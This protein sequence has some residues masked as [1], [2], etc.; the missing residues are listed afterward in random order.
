MKR[1]YLLLPILIF[2]VAV[3]TGCGEELDT[4]PADEFAAQDD[5]PASPT[6]DS[7]GESP[8]FVPGRIIVKF[9][10]V[11][12]QRQRA[13]EILAGNHVA[14]VV[15]DLADD[16]LL[17]ELDAEPTDQR[18]ILTLE[19]RTLEAI[20]TL[21]G[22]DDVEYVHEDT[23]MQFV[24]TPTDP[25]YPQQWSY[26][27]IG[28]PQAWNVVTGNKVIAVL[29]TGKLPHP[30]FTSRWLTGYDFYE[31][32]ADATDTGT[33]H[34]GLHVAGILAARTNN[35]I[36]GAGVCWGC[37][38]LP[39]RVGGSQGVSISS[40]INAIPW[41]VQQGAK[42]INMSFAGG[43]ACAQYP[44]LQNVINQATQSGAVLVAAA[45]NTAS[46]V[47]SVIPASCTNVIAV[48]ASDQGG[49]LASYSNRGSRI[50]I[51]APG[52]GEPMYGQ[53]I[54]CPADPLYQGSYT[55][56][57]GVVASWAISKP[58]SQLLSSD[59]CHRYLSGTSMAAPHVA[60]VAALMLT[61]NPQLTPAQVKDIIKKA[62]PTPISCNNQCGAGRINAYAAVQAA[63][64]NLDVF[65]ESGG[66]NFICDATQV[67]G[68]S[69]YTGQWQGVTNAAVTSSLGT[70]AS[71]VCNVNQT[72]T[73]NVTITDGAGRAVT[74]QKSFMCQQIWQ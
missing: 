18:S 65:C 68:V 72:A 32:D 12:S 22:R 3:Y 47:A 16:A 7:A 6:A 73:V 41:A 50:D 61:R 26:P 71:G 57:A 13:S 35:G 46:D 64:F 4:A 66:G 11:G 31:N 37:P 74:K 43:A 69:P 63:T 45:G 51:T 2:A 23:L 60:G 29:D 5:T 25:L 55:G 28:L 49:N 33:W 44:S 70:H 52:G 39:V 9:R 42:V 14:H 67:G 59:Y 58:G 20:D 19:E 34:H 40:V 15:Q 54:A 17:L 56:T 62:Q 27:A 53:G 38:L 1:R 36:G 21:R 30:D 24:A 8:R 10:D 48:A